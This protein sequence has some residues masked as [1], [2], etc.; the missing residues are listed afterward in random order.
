MDLPSVFDYLVDQVGNRQILDPFTKE[1]SLWK[2][3]ESQT[4]DKDFIRA[5]QLSE[6]SKLHGRSVA[7]YL[8]NQLARSSSFDRT[9][10]TALRVDGTPMAD[11]FFKELMQ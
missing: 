9:F 11:A 8:G 7:K 1:D 5:A 4:L 6:H 3:V 2:L 10:R